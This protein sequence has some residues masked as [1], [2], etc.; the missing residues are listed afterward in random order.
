[1]DRIN[2]AFHRYGRI[3]KSSRDQ[4]RSGENSSEIEFFDE[5]LTEESFDEPE[6]LAE[7]EEIRDLK[8]AR[9]KILKTPPRDAYV[10]ARLVVEKGAPEKFKVESPFTENITSWYSDCFHRMR[11]N[12]EL[13]G[14]G[15]NG[16]Q[17]LGTFCESI[18]SQFYRGTEI[19]SVN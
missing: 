6:T 5:E 3:T 11:E 12:H 8:N 9:V 10:R 17:E 13:I 14:T 19:F 15:N 4:E 18:T 1:M 2:K 7:K 16:E